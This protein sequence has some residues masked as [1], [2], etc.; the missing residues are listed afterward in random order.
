MARLPLLP[1]LCLLLAFAPRNGGAGEAGAAAE[2]EGASAAAD[3]R[4][5]ARN[6]YRH[7][8]E[9]VRDP[10]TGLL[11]PE[12]ASL[13]QL[14][15]PDF[16][17]PVRA[18]GFPEYLVSA[19][20]IVPDAG[21][22]IP[23]IYRDTPNHALKVDYDGTRV[24][25]RTRVPVAVDPSLAYE[26]SATIRDAN[27]KGARIRT[28]IDWLR[29]DP[30]ASR[31]LR[32]DDIP[33][34]GTGQ[35]D[36]PVVPARM[37]VNDPPPEANAA[38]MFIIV[39][40][41]PDSIGGA[42][43]G[44]VWVDNVFLKPLPKI[45]IDA[46]RNADGGGGRSIPVHYAGL[47]DNIPDPENFGYFKGKR[48]TRQVEITDVSGQP[49]P[50]E[51]GGKT[52]VT[53]GEDGLA[54]EDIPFPGD[55][56][57]VYYFN[58]RL[59][60]AED[61]LA[62]DVMRAVAVMRPARQRDALTLQSSRPVFGVTAGVPPGSVL[63][64]PGFLRDILQRSGVKTTKLSPWSDDDDG[65][66]GAARYAGLAEEIRNIR[67]AGLAVYGM[68]RPP[69]AL[70]GA[71]TLAHAVMN[72][73]EEFEALLAEAGQHVGLFLDGW[74]WGEDGDDSLASV[75]AGPALEA[76]DATVGEFAG[77]MPLVN[78]VPLGAPNDGSAA[79]AFPLRRTTTQGFF[80]EGNAARGIWDAA[81]G[82]YPWLYEAFHTPRGLT[83]PPPQL[84]ALAPRPPQDAIEAAAR[85]K[86]RAGSWIFL[87]SRPANVHEPNAP[88][89]RK[90]LE[91]MLVRAVYA[92]AL[93]PDAVFL[94]DLFD[95]AKGLLRRDI[96]GTNTLETMARPTFLAAST[97]SALLEGVEYLG[98]LWLLPPFEA[99]V[100]RRPGSD[101]GV[102]AIWHNDAK[103]TVNLDRQEIASGPP[104]LLVDWAGNARAI[105]RQIPVRR[106]PS[107]ITGLSA[108]LALTRM[109]MRI[110]PDMPVLAQ[111][112]RQNQMLEVVNHMPRQTPLLLRLR[113]AARLPGGAMENGWTVRPDEM[114]LN[115][116]PFSPQLAPG[117]ARYGVSPDPNSQAQKAAP[118]GADKSALKIAQASVSFNTSPPADMLVYLPF[119][120]RSELDVE[121]ERLVRQNDPNFVTLQ[122]KIRWYPE[123]GG[124]ARR[125]EIKLTPYYV[126]RGQMR[127]SAA[128]PV[129]VKATATEERGKDTAFEAVE[130]RIPRRP[131]AQ[132]WAGLEEVNGSAYYLIDVTEY[133]TAD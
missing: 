73:P 20:A 15:W 78:T 119:N 45:R 31:L 58:I 62:T 52:P 21:S 107:F 98:E 23:G 10:G 29:I 93:A 50:V 123:P 54:V 47:F 85:A 56:F 16:W 59:Y 131:Q 25:L 103:D 84:T 53:A 11:L 55:Q 43:H 86:E 7:D 63:K 49:V 92:T 44:T 120:L 22:A 38:R 87:E 36:W 82:V 76:L 125:N 13:N 72:R 67:S 133:L 99:H 127:E 9:N 19:V 94:G 65:T 28:G 132:T 3:R 88:A 115:L 74:Q 30:S 60:D 40:R 90:Q 129:T 6:L 24:G 126:K 116:S 2:R 41:D 68:I 130:I 128:F 48:Y 114:R 109:S 105:G 118:S 110:N 91:E 89:E 32:S 71:S 66:G 57:G 75:P 77:G 100:F 69:A 79:P 104:L 117:R 46:P 124:G 26:Y 35:T 18:V 113:Y 17:E 95:P 64:S 1:L 4:R 101:E 14:N 34:L 80:P 96:M 51:N 121:V 97:L 27:L 81:A 12:S 8:F 111:T 106:V 108:G 33:G 83:Y 61:R 37:L 39:D 70:F 112:R 5:I 122:L 102:I 42:Y